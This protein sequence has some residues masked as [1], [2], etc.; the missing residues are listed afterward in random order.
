MKAPG[1]M[2]SAQGYGSVVEAAPVD[3]D[4]KKV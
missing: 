2:L 1:Y 4:P 3:L